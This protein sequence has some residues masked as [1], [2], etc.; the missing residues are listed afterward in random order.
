MKILIGQWCKDMAIEKNKYEKII[1][2]IN[3][4]YKDKDNKPNFYGRHIFTDKALIFVDTPRKEDAYHSSSFTFK[5]FEDICSIHG[6]VVI[7]ARIEK[8]V[9]DKIKLQNCTVMNIHKHTVPIS[10][11]EEERK[12]SHIH[13]ACSNRNYKSIINITKFLREY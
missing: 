1:D 11:K 8:D 2:I 7:E 3:E 6:E 9:S 10:G 13:F 4:P 12:E 5:C